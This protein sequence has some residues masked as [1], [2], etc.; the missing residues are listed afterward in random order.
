M[1]KIDKKGRTSVLFWQAYYGDFCADSQDRA[2]LG[3][4]CFLDLPSE[5]AMGGATNIFHPRRGSALSRA[6]SGDAAAKHLRS[7]S[8]RKSSSGKVEGS[9]YK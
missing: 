8:D 3:L 5:D 6:S 4:P 7:E 2:M 9:W 1:E